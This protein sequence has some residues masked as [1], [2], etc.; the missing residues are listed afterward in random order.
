[1]PERGELELHEL[2]DV[3]VVVRDHDSCHDYPSSCAVG[4]A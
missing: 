3:D 1:M 2:T 4:E